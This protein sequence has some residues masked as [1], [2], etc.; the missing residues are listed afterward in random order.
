M[1]EREKDLIALETTVVAISTDDRDGAR[2]LVERVGIRFPVLYDPQ[3]KVI[4]EWG[5]YN[6]FNDRLA[7][8][9]TF[10]VD[11]AG[12]V[13][14]SYIAKNIADEPSPDLIIR[15]LRSIQT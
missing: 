7:T 2:N 15:Q 6:L 12:R 8:P 3:A 5:V 13:R 10:I 11:K 9:S 1:Q 4:S 14:W